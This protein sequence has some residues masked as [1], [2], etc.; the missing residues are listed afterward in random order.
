MPSIFASNNA[1]DVKKELNEIKE[2]LKVQGE[3]LKV[4]GEALK[5]QGEALND[6]KFRYDT[7]AA[8]GIS[9]AVLLSVLAN[10]AK[11]LEY[12]GFK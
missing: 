2:M 7:T 1:F 9:L 10:A 4:Q 12:L 11:L 5:V 6:L 8:A 3:A